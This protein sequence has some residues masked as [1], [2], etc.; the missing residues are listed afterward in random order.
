[1]EKNYSSAAYKRSRGAYTAQCAFEYFVALLVTDVFLAKLLTSIGISDELTGIISSFI[2]LAFIIQLASIFL[3]KTKISTKKLVIIGDTVSV[4]FFML[5]YLIPFIPIGKTE[6]T[7]IIIISII[8]A[9][10]S[11]YLILTMCYHWGNSFVEP[12]KRASFSAT[13]E[14]ISLVSG[15]TFTVIV[16]YII[17]KFESVGNLN[18]GFLFI[19][20]SIFILNICEFICLCMIKKEDSLHMPDNTSLKA[21]MKNTVGNKS[22]KNIIILTIM[23]NVACYFTF[24]FMGTFKTNDLALSIFSVQIIN[25]VAHIIRA[26][27]SKPFGKYSD[28]HSFAKGFKLALYIAAAA[29]FINIFTSNSTW[30]LVI[31]YTILY[32]CCQAGTSQ[33]SYNMTY[34]YVDLEYITQAMAIK[35]SLGGLC[36]FGASIIAGKLLGIIQTNGNN[37]FGIHIYGQQVLS[38]I[39]FIIVIAAI[40]FTKTKIE[41]QEIKIQ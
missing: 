34:S 6:K 7:I 11:N 20:V 14:I 32:D 27:I 4:F 31:I 19:A 21:V 13:K 1:M 15:M 9:Y 10:A 40:I 18:G 25:I 35:N 37:L 38:A 17:D 8:I 41:K 23:W 33:N 22:F 28:Q 16:G 39:S 5:L 24:G 29:F 36:G 3:V 26:F 30:F 12:R 2:S